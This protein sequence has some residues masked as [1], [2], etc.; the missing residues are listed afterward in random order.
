MVSGKTREVGIL[1]A[2]GAS[3]KLIGRIFLFNG[4]MIGVIGTLLGLIGGLIIVSLIPYLPIDLPESVYNF[5]R[6]PVQV[7]PLTV[8]AIIGASMIICVISA[9]F[10]A[11]QAAK[12]S[13]VEA[14]R[15]DS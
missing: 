12:M 2:M 15:H 4:L 13:P 10:P 9:V 1:K 8:A 3:E 5:D 7:E 6:L 11:R 14:L